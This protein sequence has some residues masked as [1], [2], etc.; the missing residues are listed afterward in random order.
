[1]KKKKVSRRKTDDL[2]V[3]ESL[4]AEIRT[5]ADDAISWRKQNN[6]E[7]AIRVLTVAI[8]QQ[9]E[10][11]ERLCSAIRKQIRLHDPH[12]LGN[13]GLPPCVRIAYLCRP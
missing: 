3:A 11:I 12:N 9:N 5:L 1:M 8:L 10:A 6:Y 7:E 13:V 4:L 2:T